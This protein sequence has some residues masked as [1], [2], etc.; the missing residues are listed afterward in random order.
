MNGIKDKVAIVT[1]G[2]TIIG[3]AVAASLHAAGA[4]VVI[5]DIDRDGGERVAKDLGEGARFIATDITDDAQIEQCVASTVGTYGGVDLLINLACSYVDDGIEST[6]DD[7]NQSLSVNVVG[8]VMMAK[9][10][11]PHMVARGGGAIVNFSSI[12]AKVAQTGRWLYPV[13]KAAVAQ[14][15]RNMAMDL[16]GE[17][18][19]VNSVS[20]GW[21]WS[22]VMDELTQGNRAKTDKVAA[23]FH[24]LGR[25]GD[26]EEVANA[27]V[28]LC[29]SQAS[30]ITG[31]DLAVD[32]GYSAMGPEQGVPAIPLLAQ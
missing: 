9:A 15:T 22:R 21:T 18:I 1:G 28:F 30:F 4:R 7:W 17:G 10:C 32:G 5:A 6:R 14:L 16:A 27:V 11:R 26:P 2:A 8:A 31:A 13:G 24:M 25:V 12:S 20:P 3:A 23:P 29:S 19:R